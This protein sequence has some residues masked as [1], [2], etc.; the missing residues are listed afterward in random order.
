MLKPLFLGALLAGLLALA[1]LVLRNFIAPL[2]WA[3]ILAYITWPLHARLTRL[4]GNNTTLSALL[5]VFVLLTA[6]VVP[7]VWLTYL[8]Q[9][10]LGSVYHD[11]GELLSRKPTLPEF[12]RKLP[13]VGQD[14]QRLF[15]QFTD[16][17]TLR[18]RVMPW[19]KSFS[20]SFLHFL[21]DVG[22]IAAMLFL[23]LFSV[24]FFYRDGPQVIREVSRVLHLVMGGRV[25]AY[26]STAGSTVKA[27]VYGLVLTAIGQGAIAGLGYWFVGLKSPV[28]LTLVTMLF[29]MI[30][31]GTPVVWIGAGLWL[32]LQGRHLAGIELLVWGAAVVSWV[33]N[34]IRPLVISSNT[35]IPF[36]L[37]F[38][39]VLGGL[40]AFGFIGLF[41][42][43]VIL[44][45]VLAVWREWLG[46]HGT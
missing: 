46:Q 32:L 40:T 19:M 43:P 45:V 14:A 11:L 38:F 27:V 23:T 37:V 33:D 35:S 26:L 9:E 24:F 22:Y 30:P 29:A 42:G 18:A 39:G 34:L 20:V 13:A 31:F 15:D 44:A 10:E 41:V 17:D 4:M 16:P 36:L 28:L 5:M 8:L 3:I 1:Y 12:I 25:D 6:I 21:G 7:S 2:A